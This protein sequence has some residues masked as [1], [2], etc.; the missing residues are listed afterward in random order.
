MATDLRTFVSFECQSSDEGEFDDKGN[1]IRPPGK[2]I[3]EY[4]KSALGV[5]GFGVTPVSQHSFYGWAFEARLD[6]SVVWCLLQFP[7]PWLVLTKGR[8]GILSRLFSRNSEAHSRVCRAIH[9]SLTH[10]PLVASVRWLREE[11]MSTLLEW[12]ERIRHGQK[13]DER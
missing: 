4:L 7:G 10:N 8:G 11:S 3:A 1:A 13:D 12:E 5:E 2:E 6:K 9:K